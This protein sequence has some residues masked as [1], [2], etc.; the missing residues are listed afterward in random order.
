MGLAPVICSRD[1]TMNTWWFD[2]ETRRF[3]RHP[4]NGQTQGRAYETQRLIVGKQNLLATWLPTL[5]W[6]SSKTP[7]CQGALAFTRQSRAVFEPEITSLLAQSPTILKDAL[8]SFS[9]AQRADLW[10]MPMPFNAFG[11]S[12]WSFDS[13][14]N[15]CFPLTRPLQHRRVFESGKLV[16]CSTQQSKG[17]ELQ[18]SI[19]VQDRVDSQEEHDVRRR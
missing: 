14:L 3:R 11:I 12:L 6:I 15:S 16:R 9:L 2:P 19:D 7:S 4:T 18:Q 8:F 17:A 1:R 10:T 13:S 5:M